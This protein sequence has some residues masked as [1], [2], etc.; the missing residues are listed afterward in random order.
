[1][2]VSNLDRDHLRWLHQREPYAYWRQSESSEDY[3][4]EQLHQKQAQLQ[5]GQLRCEHVIWH[6]TNRCNLACAHCGVRGGETRY[7]EISLAQFARHI[8]DMLRMGVK[9][10]TLTGGEPLVRQDIAA[11][12]SVLKL[13]G[14]KVAMVTNG[15]Y[16]H[17]FADAFAEH[18]LDSISISID[19]TSHFHDALRLSQGSY[20]QT[21]DALACAREWGIPI[22]NVNTCITPENGDDL[23]HLA[24]SIF[25]AGANHWVLR[26]V[27]VA[28]RAQAEMKPALENVYQLLLFARQCV[29]NGMNVKVAGLG[30]LERWD[31]FF[32]PVPFFNSVGWTNL[33]VLPN[34]DIKGFNSD[35]LPVEGSLLTDSL[36]Q[37]WQSKFQTYREVDLPADCKTCEHVG[38]CGGGNATEAEEGFR[39]VKP[40]FSRFDI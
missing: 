4:L 12:V 22:R 34:G 23:A 8:P 35:S 13:S 30:F 3:A 14:F 32:S 28:G 36:P 19:G 5:A 9:Y 2:T 7:A 21:L 6:V 25:A 18:P 39:C 29:F 10:V 20:Q 26:P 31:G 40:L 11:I 16:L 24:E 1:M 33:Y 37:V 15:H 17:R 38:R 27:T